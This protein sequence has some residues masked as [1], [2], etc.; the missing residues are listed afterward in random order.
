MNKAN[1]SM[2]KVLISGAG[3]AG[4]AAAIRLAKAGHDVT[5]VEKAKTSRA[6]GYL[7]ALSHQSYI[8]ADE[9]GLIPDLRPYD[10]S[11][12]SS[13]YHNKKGRSL[14]DLDYSAMM[15]KLDIIQLMRGDLAHVLY[16]H[17]AA[18]ADIRFGETI[19]AIDDQQVTLSSGTEEEFDIIIGAD[20]AHSGLR[21]LVFDTNEIHYDYLDLHCA[22]F[23][24]PNV[25]GIKN[26]FETHMER[27]RYMAAFNTLDG[28]IGA[29]FV[30]ANDAKDLP[31]PKDR[32]AYL[33]QSFAG[34]GDAINTV[35]PHCP[36]EGPPY[37]DVLRQIHMPQ[38]YK[39]RNVLVGDA[40]HCLTLF[41]GRGAAA[42]FAGA[43]RLCNAILAHDT[44]QAAFQ[45]YE[46]QM[47]PVINDI[48]PA[49]RSAVKWYVPISMK[50]HILRD[51]LM[52]FVPNGIFRKY[53]QMK[54]SNV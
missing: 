41:S 4:L 24:L 28:D 52:R 21:D 31:S 25:L 6:G 3:I 53:F 33:L 39:G 48:M 37:M 1:S 16:N 23:R 42:A 36:P 45:A 30:W 47:R 8:F 50:N 7:V 15:Q 13:S 11:I 44:P 54:Y 46:A 26:K 43:C 17:A 9:M 10:L 40:A 35:L 27:D 38:W 19:T 49:T 12:R 5:I 29:V 34:T 18:L 51:G 22:A 2:H 20:G 32:R 14:L